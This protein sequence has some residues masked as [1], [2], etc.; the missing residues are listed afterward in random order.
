MSKSFLHIDSF[1]QPFGDD[2]L[3]LF[4][5]LNCKTCRGICYD[6]GCFTLVVWFVGPLSVEDV[7]VCIHSSFDERLEED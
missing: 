1:S 2:P 3:S 4:N 6:D 7:Y 5:R